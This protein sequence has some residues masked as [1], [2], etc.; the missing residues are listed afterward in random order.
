[1]LLLLDEYPYPSSNY[2]LCSCTS[3]TLTL[4]LTLTLILT[5][6]LARTDETRS[7]GNRS[8]NILTKPTRTSPL[9]A[10]NMLNDSKLQL[11][12]DAKR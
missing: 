2:I 7:L 12:R 11:S 10:G 1:M 4:T 5:L 8:L 3:N 6:I 9:Q